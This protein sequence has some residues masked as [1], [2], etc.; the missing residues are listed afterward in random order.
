MLDASIDEP[1]AS[2]E[3]LLS[4]PNRVAV[5]LRADKVLDRKTIDAIVTMVQ[6]A[7]E[8]AEHGEL[9]NQISV[10]VISDSEYPDGLLEQTTI[11]ALA[12]M[13]RMAVEASARGELQRVME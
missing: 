3:S 1:S 5:H 12:L 10:H 13:A 7:Y 8:A 9:R 2:L 4:T 6:V 11:D